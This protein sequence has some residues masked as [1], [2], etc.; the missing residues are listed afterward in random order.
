MDFH[1]FSFVRFV[2]C[3]IEAAVLMNWTLLFYILFFPTLLFVFLEATE[4]VNL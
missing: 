3:Q 1:V 2:V 4:R